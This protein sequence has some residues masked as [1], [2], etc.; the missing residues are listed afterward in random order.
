M[1]KIFGAYQVFWCFSR[2]F[3]RTTVFVWRKILCRLF[4][5][6]QPTA[7]GDELY[8]PMTSTAALNGTLRPRCSSNVALLGMTSVGGP[9]RISINSHGQRQGVSVKST[10][11]G[12]PFSAS[13]HAINND[14][15]KIPLIKHSSFTNGTGGIGTISFEESESVTNTRPDSTTESN[16]QT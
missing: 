4:C 11:G 12:V 2:N 1:N 6:S 3:R 15:I 5:R 10:V 16:T 13:E 8:Y 7:G 9:T 14:D